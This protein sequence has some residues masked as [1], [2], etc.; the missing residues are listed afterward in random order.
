MGFKDFETRVKGVREK[1]EEEHRQAI[2]QSVT[3]VTEDDNTSDTR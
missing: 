2:E 1:I 3:P